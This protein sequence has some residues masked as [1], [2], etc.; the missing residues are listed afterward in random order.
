MKEYDII[1]GNYGV[2]YEFNSKGKVFTGHIDYIGKNPNRK[3][4]GN[5]FMVGRNNIRYDFPLDVP[6]YVHQGLMERFF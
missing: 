5:S 1:I 6:K 2:V 3:R 4:Q